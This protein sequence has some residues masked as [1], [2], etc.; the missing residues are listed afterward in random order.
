MLM[1]VIIL[2]VALGSGCV[3][4]GSGGPYTVHAR[5][6]LPFAVT[7]PHKAFIK[8]GDDYYCISPEH[9]ES[10]RVFVIEMDSLVRKYEHATEIINN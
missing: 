8:C 9:L 6:P 2:F 5:P 3:S 7:T 4:S 1:L 10:L